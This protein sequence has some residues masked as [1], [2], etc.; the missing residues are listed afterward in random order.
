MAY[1]IEIENLVKTFGGVRALDGI[2]LSVPEN[3]IAAVIGPN[4]SGKTTLLN[5][6]NG[7]YRPEKGEVRFKGKAITGQRPHIT[8]K[9]GIGRTFQI[10]RVFKRVTVV[11]NILASVLDSNKSNRQIHREALDLLE[12]VGMLDLQN[13]LA[14]ELS[15]GQQKLLELLRLWMR[16]PEL[17]LLDEPFAGVHPELKTLFFEQVRTMKKQGKTFILISHD[18]KSVYR[19]SDEIYVF[20]LGRVIAHGSEEEIKADE[21]V[22]EAY[23]GS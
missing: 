8:A 19:L 10:P 15:G 3:T 21:R 7:I 22:I 2:S 18:M 12:Q 9:L 14:E 17:V 13:S 4:G 20:D 23:L 1:L 5:C 6:I 16:D 11:D